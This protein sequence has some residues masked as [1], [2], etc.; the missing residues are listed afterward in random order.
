MPPKRA[1][2]IATAAPTRRS[3][4]TTTAASTAASTSASVGKKR[5]RSPEDKVADDGVDEEDDKDDKAPPKKRA[6]AAKTSKA[7]PAKSDDDAQEPEDD[8]ITTPETTTKRATRSTGKSKAKGA[9]AK[10]N[11]GK[12][13][14]MAD[15]D[16]NDEDDAQDDARDDT[17]AKSPSPPAKM[18]TVIKRGAAPV[19]PG[20][21]YVSTH[22]VYAANGEVWDAMLNQ[23][24]NF[25][26]HIAR[27]PLYECNLRL[28]CHSQR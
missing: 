10:A 4:R 26:G 7:K 23:V 13:V 22:Q 15:G 24:C 21:N 11:D 19:D 20:S 28:Q 6:K 2:T 18:V 12:D 1:K 14:T 27:L 16:A 17:K 3:A 8:I 9:K 25:R 5:A